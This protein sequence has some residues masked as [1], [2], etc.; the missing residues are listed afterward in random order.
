MSLDSIFPPTAGLARVSTPQNTTV[1]LRIETQARLDPEP[2]SYF[3][4]GFYSFCQNND[5]I[6]RGKRIQYC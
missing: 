3:S 1:F 6:G 4:D 5:P 2:K